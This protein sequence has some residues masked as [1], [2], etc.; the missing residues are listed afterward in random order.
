MGSPTSQAE[1]YGVNASI[2]W[3]EGYAVIVNSAAE[4]EFATRVALDLFGESKVESN[5]PAYT[6]S[7]DFA[8]MLERVPGS[9]FFIGNGA[10]GSAGS[11]HVHNPGYD[12]NDEIIAP[13]AA[14]WIS[15][16]NEFFKT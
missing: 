8:F 12:F 2:D 9:Y 3:K 13:G 14:F 7:E 10:Q 15:L 6:A 4:T 1:S 11:C 5:G 16:T